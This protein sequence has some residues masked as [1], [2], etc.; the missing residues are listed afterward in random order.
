MGNNLLAFRHLK[1]ADTVMLC[2]CITPALSQADEPNRVGRGY[3][4]DEGQRLSVSCMDSSKISHAGGTASTIQLGA[5]QRL[6]DTQ[7]SI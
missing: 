1:L 2:S 3:S 6:S 4:T 5:Q 7:S